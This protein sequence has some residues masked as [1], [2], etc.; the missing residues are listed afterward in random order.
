MSK[1]N[2][3]PLRTIYHTSQ[4]KVEGYAKIKFKLHN[5]YFKVTINK[6]LKTLY[7]LF[8]LKILYFLKH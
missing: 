4:L 2:K 3:I 1:L 6:E 7:F 8:S 5:L